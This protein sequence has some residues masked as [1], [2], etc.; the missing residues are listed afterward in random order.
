MIV[1]DFHPLIVVEPSPI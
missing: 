1:T